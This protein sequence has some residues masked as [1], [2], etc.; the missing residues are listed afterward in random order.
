MFTEGADL[1]DITVFNITNRAGIGKGT[2]YDYF[3]S[4]EELI[5]CAIV[6]LTRRMTE[7]LLA[8]LGEKGSFENQIICLFAWIDDRIGEQKCFTR[9]MHLMSD[10]S[11]ISQMLHHKIET[12]K[13]EMPFPIVLFQRMLE[14]AVREGEVRT[15]LPMEYMVYTVYSRLVSYVTFLHIEEQGKEKHGKMKELVYQSIIRE[16]C[17]DQKQKGI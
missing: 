15:D 4:K 13:I 6:Y 12:G 11:G 7:R 14:K 16:L 8:E 1:T 10:H 17:V 5:A 9:F 3:D 2:A